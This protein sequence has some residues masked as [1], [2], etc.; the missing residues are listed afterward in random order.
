MTT[1]INLKTSKHQRSTAFRWVLAWSCLLAVVSGCRSAVTTQASVGL[2]TYQTPETLPAG[3]IGGRVFGLGLTSSIGTT[4]NSRQL[5]LT[6]AVMGTGGADIEIGLGK[7]WD[8]GCMARYDANFLDASASIRPYAKVRFTE[9][10]APLTAA[11]LFGSEFVQG[12]SSNSS[13]I[14]VPISLFYQPIPVV[15]LFDTTITN[16]ASSLSSNALRIFV[17]VPIIFAAGKYDNTT[18]I[19]H[20]GLHYWEQHITQSETITTKRY[21]ANSIPVGTPQI[22]SENRNNKDISRYL[23]PS[24]SL[25]VRGQVDGYL[26]QPEITF[27]PVGTNLLWNFG[28]SFY[29]GK[30]GE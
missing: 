9:D 2:N 28:L 10:N 25:S 5:Q 29:F 17:S 21:S 12:S 1:I 16:S 22:V 14:Y 19:L 20:P 7:G 4:L 11:I 18:F 13:Q 3:N 8:I 15:P 6:S 26:I 30:F 27:A 23:V 24:I